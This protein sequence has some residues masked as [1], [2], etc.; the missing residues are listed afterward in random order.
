MTTNALSGATPGDA[1]AAAGPT[2]AAGATVDDAGV[3]PFVAPCRRLDPRASFGWIA[4]GWS[5]LRA[6]PRQSLT[7]SVASPSPRPLPSDVLT[8]SRGQSP[9]SWTSPGFWSRNPAR[10]MAAGVIE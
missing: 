2:A 7:A 5:D 4:H 10:R 9:S 1:P 6:A 3:L 8:A